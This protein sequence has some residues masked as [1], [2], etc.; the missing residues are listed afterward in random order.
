[1]VLP[2]ALRCFPMSATC[3][4][5]L[6]DVRWNLPRTHCASHVT[7]TVLLKAHAQEFTDLKSIDDN[8]KWTT[9]GEFIT[10]R[11][12]EEGENIITR[13]E[14]ALVSLDTGVVVDG[15]GSIKTKVE[16]HTDQY[17]HFI[18]NHHL[19]HK[20]GVVKTLLPKVDTLMSDKRYKVEKNNT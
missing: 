2:L 8:V 6:R 16:I 18:C 15:E 1:M 12:R 5:I 4:M 9:E 13:T 20:R 10:D 17:I 19:L 3:I 7:H 11:L 14:Q